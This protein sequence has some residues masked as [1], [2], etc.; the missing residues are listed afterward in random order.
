MEQLSKNVTEARRP[1]TKAKDKYIDHEQS[2]HIKVQQR[3]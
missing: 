1:R 3:E 2:Y